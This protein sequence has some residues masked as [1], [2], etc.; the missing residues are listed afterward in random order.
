[1][2]FPEGSYEDDE[3]RSGSGEHS[4]QLGSLKIA[5]ARDVSLH[6]EEGEASKNQHETVRQ[7]GSPNTAE[8]DRGTHLLPKPYQCEECG[9]RFRLILLLQIHQ[10][11]HAL[12][13][14][15]PCTACK[16][17]FPT[18]ER[19]ETHWRIHTG[20]KPHQCAECGRRFMWKRHLSI[21]AR[22]HMKGRTGQEHGEKFHLR[23]R[24]HPERQARSQPVA[25]LSSAGSLAR[26]EGGPLEETVACSRAGF[27]PP[28]GPPSLAGDTTCRECGKTFRSKHYAKLHE[29]VHSG[30]K[31]Y[32]CPHCGKCFT[33]HSN[34]SRHQKTHRGR[35]KP[36]QKRKGQLHECAKC[37]KNFMSKSYLLRHQR[38]HVETESSDGTDSSD[39]QDGSP[40]VRPGTCAQGTPPEPDKW[41]HRPRRQAEKSPARGPGEQSPSAESK[42]CAHEIMYVAGNR[43]KCQ[44]CGQEFVYQERPLANEASYRCPDCGESFGFKSSLR[45]HCRSHLGKKVYTCAQCG[46]G[47]AFPSVLHEHQRT[48][49]GERLHKCSEC[50]KAFSSKSYLMIHQESA[51]MGIRY[52]CTRC[53]K[54]YSTKSTFVDHLKVHRNHGPA[55]CAKCLGSKHC[56]CTLKRI[57]VE[58]GLLQQPHKGREPGQG[59]QTK[60]KLPG[61]GYAAKHRR[62]RVGEG[63]P[64]DQC[65]TILSSEESLRVHRYKH[66]RQSLQQKLYV[67]PACGKSFSWRSQFIVHQRSHGSAYRCAV[68]GQGFVNENLLT[69]HRRKH[70]GE[71]PFQ[72]G[73]CGKSFIASCY[74]SLHWKTHTGE[75]V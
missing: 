30:E 59:S 19:L 47:F 53:R 33:F 29:R 28:T 65:G 5:P 25:G 49:L 60:R 44:D 46:E 21:H 66:R 15:F 12:E 58:P 13:K 74:L 18:A 56:F 26:P 20:E 37:G 4:E 50:G 3:G 23:L 17:R 32:V 7:Q 14:H 68:C 63:Y 72:C 35:R 31:P 16:K 41:K 40:A 42:P 45:I 2:L 67:C 38:S 36:F 34:F 6:P 69:I 73:E 62:T 57:C 1:M 54:S 55:S 75:T 52:W 48:H 61:K 70:T 64:C 8:Q 22:G 71:R 51:H 27:A 10:R 43:H 9:K 11:V 39:S 24:Q